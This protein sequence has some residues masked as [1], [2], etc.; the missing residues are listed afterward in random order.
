MRS[1]EWRRRH[2]PGRPGK[3]DG[4]PEVRAVVDDL[5]NTCTFDQIVAHCRDR[6]GPDRAP[7]KSAISR[8][9]QRRRDEFL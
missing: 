1:D 5:L 8:Y 4:D 6:F 9:W 7:S 3:I 2:L